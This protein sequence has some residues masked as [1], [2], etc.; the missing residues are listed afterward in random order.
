MTGARGLGPPQEAGMEVSVEH[1]S[2]PLERHRST[3]TLRVRSFYSK[4]ALGAVN[5]FLAC[6]L[7]SNCENRHTTIYSIIP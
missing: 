3:R 6:Q 5:G 7:D 4:K 1:R 2:L